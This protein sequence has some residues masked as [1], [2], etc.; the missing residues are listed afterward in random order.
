M[1]KL[2]MKIAAHFGK[3]LTLA[4][5]PQQNKLNYLQKVVLALSEA[6]VF[7]KIDSGETLCQRS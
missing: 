4:H 1:L 6:K 5:H 2:K 3:S 7:N